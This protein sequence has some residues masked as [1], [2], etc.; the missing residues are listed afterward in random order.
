MIRPG[1]QGTVEGVQ[2]GDGHDIFLAVD[3]AGGLEQLALGLHV[4][5]GLGQLDPAVRGELE[6]AGDTSQVVVVRLDRAVHCLA[7]LA[8]DADEPVDFVVGVPR[9]ACVRVCGRRL[10]AE[11]VVGGRPDVAGRVGDR[12]QLPG[13]G[14]RVL[15]RVVGSGGVAVHRGGAGLFGQIDPNRL[16]FR[17]RR[18]QRG[19]VPLA[20]RARRR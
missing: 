3:D 16:A 14:V 15:G 5:L 11:L 2:V 10:A 18:S 12:R 8:D 4:V 6:R 9:Q 20:W 1:F 13:G 7:H 17:R 19:T